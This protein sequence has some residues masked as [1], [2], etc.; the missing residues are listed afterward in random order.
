MKRS[1][2]WRSRRER[3]MGVSAG[4][5]KVRFLSATGKFFPLSSAWARG[6]VVGW[7]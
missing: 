5:E 3:G 6:L 4:L 7:R 2:L 1:L